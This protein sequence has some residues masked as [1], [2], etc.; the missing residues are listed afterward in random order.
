VSAIWILKRRSLFH[1]VE[2]AV[3][4]EKINKLNV[5]SGVVARDRWKLGTWNPSVL[6]RVAPRELEG[7]KAKE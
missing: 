1:T 3:V 6:R 4:N 2:N 5:K 7:R